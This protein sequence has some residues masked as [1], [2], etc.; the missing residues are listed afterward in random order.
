[1][2]TL[3][4]L[5]D[6]LLPLLLAATTGAYVLEFFRG[7]AAR[8]RGARIL[9]GTSL[10]LLLARFAA[11]VAVMGRAPLANRGEA[12]T[13][14]ALSVTVVYVLLELLHRERSTGFLLLGLATVFQSVSLLDEPA[15]AEVNSVLGQAWFGVHAVTAIVGYTAFAV[16]AVYATLFLLLYG[17]LKKRRFG[18]IYDQMP[19]LDVLSRMAIRAATIGFAFLTA[20]IVVG[21]R[22]WVRVVDHPVLEDPKVVSS[23]VVWAVYGTGVALHHFG[24]WRGIRSIRITL[25]AFVLMVLSSWLVPVFLDS[26]HGVKGLS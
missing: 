9:L 26:M 13:L 12:F 22:G 8:V 19:S 21:A 20:A 14:I 5:L 24:G 1:L 11:F 4:A 2:A 16:S 6:P 15:G 10:C 25:A 3:L 7:R 23:L 18:I 17:D